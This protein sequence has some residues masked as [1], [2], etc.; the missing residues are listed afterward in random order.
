LTLHQSPKLHDGV[1]TALPA[2]VDDAGLLAKQEAV[3]AALE[4]NAQLIHNG[5]ALGA[6]QVLA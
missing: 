4:V 1:S 5:G 2:G 3:A 6:L